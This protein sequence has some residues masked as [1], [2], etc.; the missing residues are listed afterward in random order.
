MKGFS[1]NDSVRITLEDTPREILLIRGQL[2]QFK[3]ILLEMN[4]NYSP[5]EPEELMTRQQ[6]ADLL[7]VNPSTV[8]NWTI[9]GRLTKYGIENTV[10]YKRS[11]VLKSLRLLK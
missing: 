4:K 11:E 9:Q 3:I 1:L 6:V 10:R 8:H 5:K 7:K 2:E